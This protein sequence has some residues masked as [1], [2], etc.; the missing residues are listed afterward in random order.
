MYYMYALSVRHEVLS[1][2]QLG[3]FDTLLTPD[4]HCLL[5]FH[6]SS[7][8]T[9]IYDV[10]QKTGSKRGLWTHVLKKTLTR[11]LLCDYQTLAYFK[12]SPHL[13]VA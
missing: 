1:P 3:D 11:L 2:V 12:C 5:S 4:N 10:W 7:G 6:A 8:N 9:C 13:V